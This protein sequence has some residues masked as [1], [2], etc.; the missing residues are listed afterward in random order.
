MKGYPVFGEH[1]MIQAPM[2]LRTW[3]RTPTIKCNRWSGDFYI[4]KS[5]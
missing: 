5:P 3:Y 1:L 2:I 4:I